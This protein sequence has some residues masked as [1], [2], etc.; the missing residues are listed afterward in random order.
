MFHNE[1]VLFFLR[2]YFNEICMKS[3]PYSNYL[4]ELREVPHNKPFE[5]DTHNIQDD[6]PRAETLDGQE[7]PYKMYSVNNCHLLHGVW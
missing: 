4:R 2:S 7:I 6:I 5:N 1:I 3:T